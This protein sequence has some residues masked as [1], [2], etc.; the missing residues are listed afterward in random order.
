MQWTIFARLNAA[1]VFCQI[2]RNHF[3]SARRVY[4]GKTKSVI[5][6]YE[7]GEREHG[8]N[9]S[10]RRERALRVMADCRSRDFVLAHSRHQ[11]PGNA[12]RSYKT[13]DTY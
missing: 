11:T 2:K 3:L 6:Q 4:F 8:Y 12:G 9:G 10:D 5:G 1:P 13:Y 7:P